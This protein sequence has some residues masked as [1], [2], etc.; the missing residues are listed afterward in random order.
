MDKH[1]FTFAEGEKMLNMLTDEINAEERQVMIMNLPRMQQM[2][3]SYAI[4]QK[5]F[6][7]NKDVRI[8]YKLNEPF[9][10][11]GY[12]ELEG[13]VLEFDDT[14]LFVQAAVLADNVEIYPLVKNKVHMNL[15]FH[16]LTRG[17]E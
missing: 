13:V 14:E 9:K 15:T 16:N 11:M 5:I 17:V 10:S 1:D 7:G 4:I 2:I 8:N 6:N 12:I 3:V